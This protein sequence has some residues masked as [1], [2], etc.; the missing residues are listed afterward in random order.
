M[1]CQICHRNHP[2]ILHI[3]VKEKAKSQITEKESGEPA[4]DSAKVTASLV[5][6]DAG[7]HI[8][9]G[10]NACK[11]SIVPVQVKLCK[12]TKV[13]Q[14]YAFL[15]PGST[16]NFCTEELMTELNTSGRKVKVLLKT[17]GQEKPVPSYKISGIKMAALK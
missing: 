15:D 11:L 7:N 4:G 8:G 10:N 6:L 5:S 3:D 17:M 13:V 12:G 9:A 1:T 14:T 16:A 2:S